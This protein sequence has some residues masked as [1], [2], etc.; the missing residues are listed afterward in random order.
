MN[1]ARIIN[2]GY[3]CLLWMHLLA[4]TLVLLCICM[5]PG[6]CKSISRGR[7]K[8]TMQCS[9]SRPSPSG[10]SLPRENKNRICSLLISSQLLTLAYKSTFYR[11]VQTTLYLYMCQHG[12]S[13][14]FTP[15]ARHRWIFYVSLKVR[16]QACWIYIYIYICVCVIYAP[17]FVH[18]YLFP[19]GSWN[20]GGTRGCR[21]TMLQSQEPL[22][23]WWSTRRSFGAIWSLSWHF[24]WLWFLD[25]LWRVLSLR[26]AQF[27]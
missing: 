7:N 3:M 22:L 8:Y 20:G 2:A 11:S 6:I 27:E 9:V 16:A 14:L 21:L 15:A 26:D 23:C 17:A 13:P 1:A 5:H 19:C 4:G 24:T 10:R 25:W 12:T 18:V